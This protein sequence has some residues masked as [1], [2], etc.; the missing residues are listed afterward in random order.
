MGAENPTECHCLGLTQLWEFGGYMRNRAVMLAQ[1]H[2][3]RAFSGSDSRR[4]VAISAQCT[5]ERIDALRGCGILL[6]S[7][8]RFELSG[9]PLGEGYNRRFSPELKDVAQ[10]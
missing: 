4:G 9:P 1:L 5:S 6:G 10:G 3:V 2:S 7:V 8:T